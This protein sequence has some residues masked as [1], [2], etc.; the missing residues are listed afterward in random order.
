MGGGGAPLDQT[1]KKGFTSATF[2][3]MPIPFVVERVPRPTQYRTLT[4]AASFGKVTR[5]LATVDMAV[6]I[7]D[8]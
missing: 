4:M 6:W 5:V 7:T 8:V 1:L 2:A 3:P